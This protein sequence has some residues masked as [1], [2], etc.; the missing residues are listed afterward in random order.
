[1]QIKT[2]AE[3]KN[4]LNHFNIPKLSKDKANVCDKD[5]TKKDLYK[6]LKSLQ[7]QKSPVRV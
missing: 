4:F 5:L 3:I 1:M 7:N 6:S 2:I